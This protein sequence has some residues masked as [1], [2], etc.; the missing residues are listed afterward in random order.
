MATVGVKAYIGVYFLHCRTDT[1]QCLFKISPRFICRYAKISTV[2][3]AGGARDAPSGPL[4]GPF[5]PRP[6][7]LWSNYG[8]LTDN[9]SCLGI[10][11]FLLARRNFPHS[12]QELIVFV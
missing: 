5:G 8:H 2:A 10:W 4:V 3:P 7:F 12:K 6:G 11:G 9:I 1:A